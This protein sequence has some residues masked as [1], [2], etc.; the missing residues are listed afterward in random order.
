ME[1]DQDGEEAIEC[2]GPHRVSGWVAESPSG[3]RVNLDF[4]FA[5]AITAR[6]SL[7]GGID[8]EDD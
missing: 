7:E 1:I 6:D 3:A 2:R 8:W 4:F 5:G